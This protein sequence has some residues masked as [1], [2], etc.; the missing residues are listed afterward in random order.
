MDAPEVRLLD[1][2]PWS[3][4][5]AHSWAMRW[6]LGHDPQAAEALMALFV[7]SHS[8]PW[9]VDLPRAEYGVPGARADLMIAAQDGDGRRLQVL[10]ETKVN[11]Q[12]TERQIQAY[13]DHAH[14]VVIYAPGLTG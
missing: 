10:L 12:L 11:D 4:G 8:G 13:L 2:V 6:M 5:Y 3:H 9:A 1:V 7:P 14:H